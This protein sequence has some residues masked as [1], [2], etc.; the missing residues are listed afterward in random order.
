QPNFQAPLYEAARRVKGGEV[1]HATRMLIT[2]A[3]KPSLSV[4]RPIALPGISGATDH[5]ERI[6]RLLWIEFAT[7]DYTP[8]AEVL[9]AWPQ[10]VQHEAALIRTLSRTL[11]DVLEE[12]ADV[13]FFTGHDR[14]SDDVPSVAEHPQNEYHTG[15]LPIIRFL[16]QLWTRLAE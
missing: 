9:A 8:I 4:R 11:V 6:D 10:E 2:E 14:A 5:P 16:A 7:P 15:F 13:G 12:A 1:N 3:V